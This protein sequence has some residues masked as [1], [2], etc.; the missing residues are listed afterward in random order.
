MLTSD[1]ASKQDSREFVLHFEWR[2]LWPGG[3]G[4]FS[5][6]NMS[7]H[8]RG[9]G[10]RILRP[11]RLAPFEGPPHPEKGV[12]G[13]GK[14]QWPASSFD[15][16]RG[17]ESC[18][19]V[20][21]SMP[22]ACVHVGCIM[23]SEVFFWSHMFN[24][25]K[26]KMTQVKKSCA[27]I[28]MDFHFSVCFGDLPFHCPWN[29][30]PLCCNCTHISHPFSDLSCGS[31]ILTVLSTFTGK[32]G[33]HQT[34]RCPTPLNGIRYASSQVLCEAEIARCPRCL[35]HILT[36][37]SLKGILCNSVA[38]TF[39]PFSSPSSPT[40]IDWESC[41]DGQ[42]HMTTALSGEAKLL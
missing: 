8:A 6:Q 17:V 9:F 41:D 33:C 22:H 39:H 29:L 31:S 18:V 4:C 7:C 3:P 27:R 14:P 24:G 37:Q 42:Q 15:I 20:T 25:K 1:C 12:L 10:A 30:K 21:V 26:R 5:F 16:P 11:P 19:S 34:L 32:P 38:L 35:W 2:L 28:S 36:F 13:L 40:P 23:I